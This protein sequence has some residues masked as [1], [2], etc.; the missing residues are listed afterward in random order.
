MQRR[1]GSPRPWAGS[2][3]RNGGRAPFPA[4]LG[5][6]GASSQVCPARNLVHDHNSRASDLGGAV[7]TPSRVPGATRCLGPGLEHLG[8]L[9]VLSAGPGDIPC[10]SRSPPLDGPCSV[11]VPAPRLV[12]GREALAKPRKRGPR[13]DST[14]RPSAPSVQAP[15]VLARRWPCP[16]WARGRWPCLTELPVPPGPARR[17][18]GGTGTRASARRGSVNTSG[19]P[20]KPQEGSALRA[21]PASRGKPE[22]DAA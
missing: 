1:R 19:F 17:G 21:K 7:P 11:H 10:V 9:T 20:R 5:R 8:V 22:A 16:G 2:P 6:P 13:A 14:G 4:T 15:R 12:A 18:R 3:T